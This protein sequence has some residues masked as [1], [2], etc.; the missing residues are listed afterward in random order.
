MTKH[1]F[2]FATVHP[3]W[4]DCLNTALQQM[5]LT[6]LEKLKLTENWLPGPEK[7]FAAFSLPVSKVN[8][9]LFGES[10][11]PRPTSANGYAFW[12]AAVTELWSPLG[13]SKKVNRATSLRNFMKMLLVAEG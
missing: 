1:N 6:Y 13:M 3:S 10:P 7:I 12:D 11:Y 8:Y 4:H 2:S 5:D 9:L